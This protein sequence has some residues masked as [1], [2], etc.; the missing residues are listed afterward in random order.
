M[1]L[2]RATCEVDLWRIIALYDH[3]IFR[4]VK[5]AVTSQA[6]MQERCDAALL[7]TRSDYPPLISWWSIAYRDVAFLVNDDPDRLHRP[8]VA[9]MWGRMTPSVPKP[10]NHEDAIVD[11]LPGFAPPQTVADQGVDLRGAGGFI[12]H[13]SLTGIR[14]HKFL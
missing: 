10:P 13:Q 6:S 2:T 3:P 12:K 1:L 4:P 5:F 8:A 11:N 14:P 7:K 9:C